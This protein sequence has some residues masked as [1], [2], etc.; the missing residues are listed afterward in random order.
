M[1][2]RTAD[3]PHQVS[4]G[5]KVSTALGNIEPLSTYTGSLNQHNWG[6]K[7]PS[8]NGARQSPVDIDETFTQVR[9][10]FQNLQLED[11]HKPTSESTTIHNNGK[12]GML[13]LVLISKTIYVC[14]GTECVHSL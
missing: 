9:L 14:G 13:S 5:S 6:K 1:L 7:F 4:G 3:V 10:Q 8:C 2:E 11:W 12:T